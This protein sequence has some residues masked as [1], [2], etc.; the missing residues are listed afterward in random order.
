MAAGASV[1]GVAA[2]LGAC[3]V[4]ALGGPAMATDLW[5]VRTSGA[6]AFGPDRAAFSTLAGA[7]YEVF[8][9]GFGVRA[10]ADVGYV[11]YPRGGRDGKLAFGVEIAAYIGPDAATFRPYFVVQPLLSASSEVFEGLKVGPEIEWRDICASNLRIALGA[12]Y[13]PTRD[14]NGISWASFGPRL[15]VTWGKPTLGCVDVPSCV[16]LPGQPC[17]PGA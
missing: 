4:L 1:K 8:V 6:A 17:P 12:F 2:A 9:D 5:G 11:G 10:G 14:A 7:T 15:T 3:S 13:A 16:P